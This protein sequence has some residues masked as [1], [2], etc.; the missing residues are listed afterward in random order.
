MVAPARRVTS[1]PG[2]VRGR[3]PDEVDA[4]LWRDES[5][6]GG[7][8]S[9]S[10][11][12]AISNS[13]GALGHVEVTEGEGVEGAGEKSDHWAFPSFIDEPG[14]PADSSVSSSS[15]SGRGGPAK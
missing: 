2:R 13:G 15:A 12:E 11:N 5:T 9:H 6:F 14:V 1:T 4:V 7:V 3:L 8:N 10:N